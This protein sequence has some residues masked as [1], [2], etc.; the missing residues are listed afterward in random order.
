MVLDDIN[1]SE[2][3][4]DMFI[5]DDDDT[6][7]DDANDDDDGVEVV[8][9]SDEEETQVDL[10]AAARTDENQSFSSQSTLILS[11]PDE[12]NGKGASLK[13]S[14]ADSENEA[15]VRFS[16]ITNKQMITRSQK[17]LKN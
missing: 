4:D 9:D 6:E 12:S 10:E 13:R 1:G 16:N 17:R 15:V 11:Q 8:D 2:D 5:C 3:L 7:D 14:Y